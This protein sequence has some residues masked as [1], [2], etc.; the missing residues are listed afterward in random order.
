MKRMFWVVL[1][2]LLAALAFAQPEIEWARCY[3][4]SG[5]EGAYSIQQTS[6]NGYVVAGYSVSS[7]DG[8]V[9]GWH[10]GDDYWIVKLDSL[11]NLIW[12]KCIGGSSA[13]IARS[14]Q[15][16]A[17][18]GYIVAGTS[19][20]N[21]GDVIGNHGNDDSWIVKLDS[22]GNTVWQ[23]CLGGTSDDF[24]NFIQQTNDNGY[25]VAGYS[26]G[27]CWIAK[28]DTLGNIVWQESFGGSRG[29]E[30]YSAQQ[31]S[32]NGYI[33]A[34]YSASND[35]DVSGNHATSG[36]NDYWVVKLDSLGN[37]I[38]Q[39]CLGGSLNDIATSV[40]QTN[41]GG[42]V[43]AGY[44]NSDDGDITGHHAGDGI[45]DYW[46]VKLDSLGNITWQKSLGGNYEDYA[47][48][49]QQT[50]DDGFIV[51][52]RTRSNNGDVTGNHTDGRYDYWIIKLSLFGDIAWQK[53]LG[54]S[55][56]EGAYSIKQTDD[57]GFAIAG[58]SP[59]ND[60][61]VAGNHGNDDFWIVKLFPDPPLTVTET[62]ISPPQTFA[63]SISPNPFN[64]V[65]RVDYPANTSVK[66]YDVRGTLVGTLSNG[67]NIWTPSKNL[68]SGI[69]FASTIDLSENKN[70]MT[71]KIVYIR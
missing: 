54:G 23:K 5:Y 25:I 24:A 37:L 30:I 4:G 31:T 11:G 70:L 17:D 67:Q 28:I 53:C 13:D 46:V 10:G 64:S 7:N 57:N 61:D 49:V 62:P 39:K 36:T 16:T 1:I 22:L 50:T 40:R 20:S 71:Q 21:N 27:D 34:G 69:Y 66:I 56:G 32:D 68:G 38:W 60:G 33:V 41:D 8:D 29:D 59:S 45:H 48:S 65:C 52:G 9:S 58:S 14:V 43:V 55:G 63:L 2:C 44:S 15:Q 19:D 12:Q 42:Y 6:D 3:G 18:G 26:A 35:G 51:A 47:T